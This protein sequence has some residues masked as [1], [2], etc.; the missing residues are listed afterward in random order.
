MTHDPFG[1]GA[2]R[3]AVTEAWRAS[4]TRFREDA[5]SE[6]DHARGWYRD[7]VVVE[8]AQ[9]AADAAARAGVPGRLTLTLEPRPDTGGTGDAG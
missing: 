9:N 7:R 6:E 8:L 3:R 4:P 5:N 1:T 2:L